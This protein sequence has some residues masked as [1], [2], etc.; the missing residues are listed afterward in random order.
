MNKENILFGIIGLLG[1]LIIGFMF[2]NS[3]NKNNA[4]P[5]TPP[6]QGAMMNQSGQLPEGHP[7]VPN[8]S[9]EDVQ[10]AIDLAKKEPDNFDAQMKAAELAYQVERFDDSVNFLKAANRIKPED[11]ETIVT[12]GNVN[13][14]AGYFEEAEKWY[15]AALAKKP[16]NPNV[17]TD[18]GL[19]F[20][21]RKTPNYDR[22]VQEFEKS[23]QIDPN[24]VQTLQNMT[25]AY[26]KK[27]NAAKAKET[28][29]KLESVAPT[30]NAISNLK[31]E[32]QKI[33]TK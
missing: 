31:Q 28:L 33:E 32:I 29:A 19:T 3:V 30:N 26:T 4:M 25:V 2:A 17:R 12:L 24:H 18:F 6:P 27:G 11:Y 1:G 22:A 7:T 16:D 14:D 20:M 9:M 5:G 23:L 10:A 15:S 21:M 8:A 13:Y